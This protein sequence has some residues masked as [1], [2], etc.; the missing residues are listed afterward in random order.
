MCPFGRLVGGVCFAGLFIAP[1]AHP[2]S[3][4][5]G[6]QTREASRAVG[7]CPFARWVW[8]PL[9]GLFY[10]RC[11]H[12]PNRPNPPRGSGRAARAAGRGC[13]CVAFPPLPR[14]LF[15]R[16]PPLFGGERCPPPTAA[17]LLCGVGGFSPPSASRAFAGCFGGLLLRGV[18]AARAPPRGWPNMAGYVPQPAIL[19]PAPWGARSAG[20]RPYPAPVVPP[21]PILCGLLLRSLLAAPAPRL[22]FACVAVSRCSHPRPSCRPM[23]GKGAPP[24]PPPPPFAR[25]GSLRS[26]S[27]PLSPCPMGAQARPLAFAGCFC[28]LL[29]SRSSWLGPLSLP[30][31]Q[32]RPH[33]LSCPLGFAV[34]RSGS[35]SLVVSVLARFARAFCRGRW[36]ARC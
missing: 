5:I 13:S 22:R 24:K 15:T 20:G 1:S 26:P 19:W 14:T 11:A 32:A 2:P 9:R 27:R 25:F 28:G 6:R 35:L 7:W 21:R 10:A 16:P 29:Y 23:G 18:A 31:A 33:A 34:S 4:P 3:R 30:S 36:R 8:C 17:G 12:P